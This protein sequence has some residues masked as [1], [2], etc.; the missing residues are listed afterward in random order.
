MSSGTHASLPLDQKV[1][2]ADNNSF[3]SERMVLPL[4]RSLH[5]IN[6]M[7]PKEERKAM[8]LRLYNDNTP[9]Q[10]HSKDRFIPT[11][12]SKVI[13]GED[14]GKLDNDLD[15]DNYADTDSVASEVAN[16]IPTGL[17]QGALRQEGTENVGAE[18]KEP[19]ANM[20]MSIGT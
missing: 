9:L 17:G 16:T 2:N 12:Q 13:I 20:G 5:S 11:A 3:Y 6:L 14:A 19:E 8:L 15:A 7:L 10:D 1:K 4:W 18:L